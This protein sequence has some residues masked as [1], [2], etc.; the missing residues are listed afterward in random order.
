MNVNLKNKLIQD[1]TIYDYLNNFN[2]RES[3]YDQYEIKE[4]LRDRSFKVCY[5]QKKNYRIDDILFEKYRTPKEQK[6]FYGG[7]TINLI[8]Y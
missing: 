4:Y 1:E 5:D 3:N 2:Y 7:K 6:I 8:E